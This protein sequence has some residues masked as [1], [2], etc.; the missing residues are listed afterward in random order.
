MGVVYKLKQEVVDFI[1]RKKREDPSLSCRKLVEI[2]SADFG[3]N[4]SK[5]SA[6]AVIKQFNLSNPV[7]RQPVYKAPKNFSIPKEKKDLLLSNIVPFLSPVEAVA[8][9]PIEEGRDNPAEMEDGRSSSEVLEQVNN[10]DVASS[11]LSVEVPVETPEGLVL[12]ESVI[13]PENKPQESFENGRTEEEPLALALPPDPLTAEVS[14]AAVPH[15]LPIELRRSDE[16]ETASSRGV[17][18]QEPSLKQEGLALFFLLAA[19]WDVETSPVLGEILGRQLGVKLQEPLLSKLEAAAIV[20]AALRRDDGT[21]LVDGIDGFLEACEIDQRVLAGWLQSL[22]DAHVTAVIEREI[23][24]HVETQLT[25][26]AHIHLLTEDERSFY[27][28]PA[29][30]FCDTDI[31]KVRTVPG[32]LYTTVE[33]AVDAFVTNSLPAVIGQFSTTDFGMLTA[34]LEAM[35]GVPGK[36]IREIVLLGLQGERVFAAGNIFPVRKAF[37][38]GLTPSQ[39][40]LAGFEADVLD[41]SRKYYDPFYGKEYNYYDGTIALNSPGSRARAILLQNDELGEKH[42]IITNTTLSMKETIDLYI[43]KICLKSNIFNLLDESIKEDNVVFNP[44][45]MTHSPKTEPLTNYIE[46]IIS[47]YFET[48]DLSAMVDARSNISCLFGQFRAIKS[49][50]KKN[51]FG[52]FVRFFPPENYAYSKELARISALMNLRGVADHSGSRIF[53]SVSQEEIS[54]H[55]G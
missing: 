13:L 11:P 41:N 43:I 42:L 12:S 4:V 35:D 46:K 18:A 5:S 29:F 53:F 31:N 30:M 23:S 6:N 3:L 28:D 25:K 34:F 52:Q 7:G 16:V 10:K 20:H 33:R 22:G 50:F 55:R 38:L 26:V 24:A 45:N 14:E 2:I 54:P 21:V 48:I 19:L 49:S 36:G 32:L 15:P 44:L 39:E 40:Q 8:L 1:V 17:W 47:L 37:V 51:D 9:P 27:V